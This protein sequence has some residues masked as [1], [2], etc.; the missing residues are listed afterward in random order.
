[1]ITF[2]F[3]VKFVIVLLL[4]ML[5]FCCNNNFN[6][7]LV[8][9]IDGHVYMIDMLLGNVAMTMKNVE[10]KPIRAIQWHPTNELQY[11][12]GSDRGNICLWDIRY[13]QKHIY[14]FCNDS[15]FLQTTSHIHPVIGLKFYNNGNSVISID[16]EGC[17]KTWYIIHSSL[18]KLFILFLIH[19]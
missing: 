7:I 3:F 1:M 4:I 17:I 5:I 16:N 13:Q 6:L 14:R 2:L 10:K 11:V 18:L 9:A 19:L 8:T 12:T 15:S